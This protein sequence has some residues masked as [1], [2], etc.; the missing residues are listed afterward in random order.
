MTFSTKTIN[1]LAK[2]LAPEII[3]SIYADERFAEFMFDALHDI[4]R[5]KVGGINEDLL[6]ELTCCIFDRMVLKDAHQDFSFQRESSQI[7]ED[8][9]KA[10]LNYVKRTFPSDYIDGAEYGLNPIPNDA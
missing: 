4:V 3:N 1:A 7:W 9:Y 6:G 8:R 10:L 2:A 5:E